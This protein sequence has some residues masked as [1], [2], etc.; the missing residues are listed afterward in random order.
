MT[1]PIARLDLNLDAINDF[2][3]IVHSV[4]EWSSSIEDEF[5]RSRVVH[6]LLCWIDWKR[7]CLNR[8]YPLNTKSQRIF[9]GAFKELYRRLPQYARWRD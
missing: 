1:E 3:R 7:E 8:G 9:D 6:L 4:I 2:D 5:E